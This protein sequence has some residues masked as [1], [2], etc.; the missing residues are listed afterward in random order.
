[1]ATVNPDDLFAVNRNDITY[2]VEQQNLMA[3]LENTDYLAVNR[4]DIT[5][6]ITG[7]EFIESVLDPLELNPVATAAEANNIWTVTVV[8]NAVGGKQPFTFTYQWN[9]LDNNG[10]AIDIAG[11]TTNSYVVEP[12]FYVYNIGCEVTVTDALDF[13]A[14]EQSNYVKVAVPVVIETV[15]LTE[16]NDGSDR[17]IA[18]DEI[19]NVTVAIPVSSLELNTWDNEDDF[20]KIYSTSTSSSTGRY[21]GNNSSTGLP[22]FIRW[23]VGSSHGGDIK[24]RTLEN[25]E[26][27][28]RLSTDQLKVKI[29]NAPNSV[30]WNSAPNVELSFNDSNIEWIDIGTD[31]AARAAYIWELYLDGVQVTSNE[32]ETPTLLSFSGDKDLVY[33][34]AGDPVKQD[35]S[36]VTP[37][38]S[39]ITSVNTLPDFSGVAFGISGGYQKY[40]DGAC[41]KDASVLDPLAG[42]QNASINIKQNRGG[43][44]IFNPPVEAG[45]QEIEIYIYSD[46]PEG[47]IDYVDKDGNKTRINDLKNTYPATIPAWT[48]Y[49]TGLTSLARIES[50]GLTTGD[51]GF[52]GLRSE[53][54]EWINRD[55]G[56]QVEINDTEV[57]LTDDTDLDLFEV[58]DVVQGGGDENDWST[59]TSVIGTEGTS[60][61]IL[62]NGD[63][64][65]G[66]QAQN[67]SAEA[68]WEFTI[69]AGYSDA[70]L[71]TKVLPGGTF[72]TITYV[73]GNVRASAGTGANDGEFLDCGVVST[74]DVIKIARNTS[75][76]F[77]VTAFGIKLNDLLLVD[78]GV[79]VVGGVKV[80]A[81]NEATPSIT[82]DGGTWV[83]G[84]VVTGPEKTITGTVASVDANGRTVTLSE[85]SAG[86][87]ANTGN[88]LLGPDIS[89]SD[90]ERFTAQSFN[91]DIK[92]KN[93]STEPITY[94]AKALVNAE[95][96]QAPETS[97]ITEVSDP[98]KVSY[99]ENCSWTNNAA[100]GS[101]DAINAFDGVPNSSNRWYTQDNTYQSFT[102]TIPCSKFRVYL[103]SIQY[104]TDCTVNGKPTSSLVEGWTDFSSLLTNGN[105]ESFSIKRAGGSSGI[106]A[107]EVDDELLI[108]DG[109]EYTT[110]TLTDDTDLDAFPAGQ[111][112]TMSGGTTPVSSA[113]TNVG[114][115]NIASQLDILEGP[116]ND[117]NTQPVFIAV[118]DKGDATSNW[119]TLGDVTYIQTAGSGG[120]IGYWYSNDLVNWSRDSSTNWGGPQPLTGQTNSR[121]QA[122]NAGG[123][124]TPVGDNAVVG[125]CT[126]S[127]PN[128]NLINVSPDVLLTLTDDTNFANFRVGDVVQS[129]KTTNARW[130]FSETDDKLKS[131]AE[132]ETS[133]T[134]LNSWADLPSTTTGYWYWY[135]GDNETRPDGGAI[136]PA[137]A[138]GG[139]GY[140]T[141]STLR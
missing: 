73:N 32:T 74:G 13:T 10:D 89:F 100:D 4:D 14:T 138:I 102:Q 87:S 112:V 29:E 45:G 82:T 135:K 33:L 17:P 27:W 2:S 61:S 60:K 57:T 54:T 11:A 122:F 38:T 95:L 134:E 86:W 96:L 21:Q 42:Y 50:I 106:S 64:S 128:I 51:L 120:T 18:T 59:L 132:L 92:S 31:D 79:T 19:I 121:Y 30:T 53:G 1:M 25:V 20:T 3:S 107:F 76:L 141:Y 36:P 114:N 117:I 115:N 77:S 129:Q 7:Q 62:F 9:Y 80:T 101:Q 16:N 140:R 44:V 52:G 139:P 85:A 97:V 65:Q 12:A 130:F 56:A 84:D 39:A 131:L 5:Y 118:I 58:G 26:A 91:V 94:S 126:F 34:K 35:N 40:G 48:W 103:H 63:I 28:Y 66:A 75:G 78:N 22:G 24:V 104:F 72:P 47:F 88:Y 68:G 90:D 133:A 23:N 98:V 136:W 15:T 113:I 41:Y 125:T 67:T 93:T 49:K 111:T 109:S 127:D 123:L 71:E 37:V 99:V 116:G 83:N 137:D 105:F 119:G 110:L 43:D 124:T 81:I 69:P 6:K 8:E 108:E 55:V 70:I 46:G